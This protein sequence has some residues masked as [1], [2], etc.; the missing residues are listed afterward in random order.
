MHKTEL[1]C[2]E[3]GA[4]AA[5][6][7]RQFLAATK[8]A[9]AIAAALVTCQ[10][11]TRHCGRSDRQRQVTQRRTALA[12]AGTARQGDPELDRGPGAGALQQ[13]QH[14]PQRQP[15]EA[16]GRLG[17][18]AADAR[19]ALARRRGGSLAREDSDHRSRM[20]RHDA[21]TSRQRQTGSDATSDPSRSTQFKQPR[22]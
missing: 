21:G 14:G 13:R 12:E 3:C 5:R 7:M 20:E 19:P 22:G 2:S 17:R 1:P 8:A 15:T 10:A 16:A 9:A 18:G 4:A 6:D 11:A